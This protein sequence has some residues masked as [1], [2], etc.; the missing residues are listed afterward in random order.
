MRQ[1]LP[2]H[3]ANMEVVRLQTANNQLQDRLAQVSQEL[4]ERQSRCFRLETQQRQAI[5]ELERTK[6]DL[7]A[8]KQCLADLISAVKRFCSSDSS[9]SE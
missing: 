3:K 1:K 7:R 6:E 2:M 8:S 9:T 4:Q 5:G